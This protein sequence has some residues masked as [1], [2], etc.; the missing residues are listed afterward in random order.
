MKL[1]RFPYD[2]MMLAD[3]FDE[4]LSTLGGVC[5]R[6]WYNRLQ[7][8]AEGPSSK[9]WSD[10]GA[11]VEN[12]LLFHEPGAT[13]IGNADAEVFPGCPLTF[14]LAELLCPAAPVL[15][16]I[17]F[18]PFETRH[19]PL[20]PA[21]VERLWHAQNRGCTRW[22]ILS[23]PTRTWHFSILVLVRCEIQA[24]DQ[25]WSLH[26]LVL[27]QNDGLRDDAL[28]ESLDFADVDADPQE[29][30]WPSLEVAQVQ[31][32]LI[33]ALRDD[34]LPELA[35]ILRRQENYLKHELRRIDEYFDGY[36]TELKDR[37]VRSHS[38]TV[39]SRLQERIAAARAERERRRNDQIQRHTIR[40]F[41][42]IDS[43]GLLAEPAWQYGLGFHRNNTFQNV[44]ALFIPRSRTWRE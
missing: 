36:Q 6:T 12:E 19:Q 34:L 20:E 30:S 24:I 33:E 18:R 39:R 29:I 7:V 16:R 31:S 27:S 26:R 44:T 41:P 25:H 10:T 23:G 22:Q 13:T 38:D 43:M 5:E 11:L 42:R 28:A 40:V 8:L 37:S 32:F 4:G 9:P 21:A 14:R 3:F 15:E 17:A 2:P 35:S 1:K